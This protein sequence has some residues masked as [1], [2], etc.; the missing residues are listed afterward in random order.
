MR[1]QRLV[2]VFTIAFAVTLALVVGQRLTAEM[3]AVIVGVV[4]GVVASIPTSLIILWAARH[5]LASS[6]R[7]MN[8]AEY[9]AEPPASDTKIIVVPAPAASQVPSHAYLPY[10][11]PFPSYAPASP[12]RQFTIIGGEPA[13]DERSWP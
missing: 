12:P 7:S 8:G 3:V 2:I 13:P 6:G 10:G 1:L 11:A 4:A 5:T 9:R